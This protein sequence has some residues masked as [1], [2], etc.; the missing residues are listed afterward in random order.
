MYGRKFPFLFVIIYNYNLAMQM[1][2]N[3]KKNAIAD[4]IIIK[5]NTKIYIIG[6][7]SSGRVFGGWISHTVDNDNAN[8]TFGVQIVKSNCVIMWVGARNLYCL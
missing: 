3:N 1:Q 7:I 6:G 2:W 4:W 8:D 5:I